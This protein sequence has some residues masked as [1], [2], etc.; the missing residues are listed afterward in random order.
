MN[1]RKKKTTLSPHTITPNW[2]HV[3][4]YLPLDLFKVVEQQAAVSR[5]SISSQVVVMLEDIAKVK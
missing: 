2:R 1:A 5:R 3:S 4:A